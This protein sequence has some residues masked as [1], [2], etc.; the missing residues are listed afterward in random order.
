MPARGF[1]LSYTP[2]THRAF[3]WSARVHPLMPLLIGV[4]GTVL[5]GLF[6][7][8]VSWLIGIVISSVLVRIMDHPPRPSPGSSKIRR[9][10][11]L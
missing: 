9:R 6:A 7:L 10:T 2:H 1:P 11:T 8:W 4:V 5:L 3:E